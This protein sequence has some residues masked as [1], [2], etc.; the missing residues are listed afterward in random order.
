MTI[1]EALDLLTQHL[2]PFYDDRDDLEEL[3][4]AA[5]MAIGDIL[6]GNDR[7]E[8]LRNILQKAHHEEKVDNLVMRAIAEHGDREDILQ[9]VYADYEK[10]VASP[11]PDAPNLLL[12][13]MTP[14]DIPIGDLSGMEIPTHQTTSVDTGG[15]AYI[16]GD[17]DIKDGELVGRDK[18]VHGD[19]VR[20][21]KVSGD[22]IAGDKVAGDKVE[23]DQVNIGELIINKFTH[24]PKWVQRAI[25][26]ITVIVL[27]IA[28]IQF[29]STFGAQ[30]VS[31]F[32]PLWMQ[33]EFNIAVLDF[34]EIRPTGELKISDSGN[35]MSKWLYEELVNSYEQFNLVD[36]EPNS[37]NGQSNPTD[38]T[39]SVG[40]A[41]RTAPEITGPPDTLGPLLMPEPSERCEA[42]EALAGEINAQ[43]VIYGTLDR[44]NNPA[45]FEL[46][47]YISPDVQNWIALNDI[48]LAANSGAAKCLPLGE[49]FVVPDPFSDAGVRDHVRDN[50]SNR[51]T[52][53][54]W[55]TLALV[56]DR[57]GDWQSAL[58]YLRH[59]EDHLRLLPRNEAKTYGADLIAT[60]I[61]QQYLRQFGDGVDN[62]GHIEFDELEL[63]LFDSAAQNFQNAMNYKGKHQH[64]AT[65]GMGDIWSYMGRVGQKIYHQ[66]GAQDGEE[67]EI[68]TRF[69]NANKILPDLLKHHRN[70]SQ[71]LEHALVYYQRANQLVTAEEDPH[72][73]LVIDFAL[74]EAQWQ[75]GQL[76]YIKDAYDEAIP[77]M[78]ALIE[79]INDGDDSLLSRAEAQRSDRL[80]AKAYEMSGLAYF[81]LADM[82]RI[83]NRLEERK[84]YLS[85]AEKFY[86]QCIAK[87]DDAV[88]DRLITNEVV[89]D[90]CQPQLEAVQQALE[91]AQAHAG[92]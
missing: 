84:T 71:S 46:R 39:R 35:E 29:W 24:L 54:F 82:L 38:P 28:I 69:T 13:N 77:N 74:A 42:A 63:A 76:F 9:S 16:S 75:A 80:I 51:G 62:A 21:D 89:A 30:I 27:G 6:A 31:R 61:G 70:L 52:I 18:H 50:V 17:V 36:G 10:A 45:E 33:E 56:Q 3:A 65:K 22:K 67:L 85:N 25:G 60:L 64:R 59:V 14:T 53:F 2:L 34:G 86:E 68:P 57:Q 43:M 5:D 11:A 37:G 26:A 40:I 73:A 83:Q 1:A 19:E 55:L 7:A 87:A 15:G 44:Q 79:A 66:N 78:T 8:F 32:T 49:L 20:G 47:F 12:T 88:L 58:T 90:F 72:V 92:E 4:R 81:Q 91:D 41:H 48:E 23:G